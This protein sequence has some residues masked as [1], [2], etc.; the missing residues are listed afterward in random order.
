MRTNATWKCRCG[1]V[2]TY[3]PERLVCAACGNSLAGHT[4]DPKQQIAALRRDNCK[5][6]RREDCENIYFPCRMEANLFRFY[7]WLKA[8]R[9]I[10]DFVY[11]PPEFDFS[12]VYKHGTNRYR[13][14]F[15]IER[16]GNHADNTNPA[17][18]V[19]YIE[20]KGYLDPKS[21]TKLKRMAKLYP[22]VKVEIIGW[23]EYQ[24]IER[25]YAALIPGWEWPERSK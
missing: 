25:E 24:Q 16:F 3:D 17:L 19:T 7:R 18:P 14:D 6:G 2:N 4:K 1:H 13:P 23:P 9:L 11:Q 10:N 12:A 5:R 15:W 22:L 21:K 20:A 8:R